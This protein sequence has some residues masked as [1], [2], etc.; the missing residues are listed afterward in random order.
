MRDLDHPRMADVAA[1]Q[2]LIDAKTFVVRSS[3]LE[4]AL[5]LFDGS[6]HAFLPVV[7]STEAEG[8]PVLVGALFQVDALRAYSQAMAETAQEQHS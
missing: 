4:V 7:A 8:T 6:K 3:S 1:C 2:A 5:P